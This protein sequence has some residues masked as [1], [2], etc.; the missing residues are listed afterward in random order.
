[1]EANPIITLSVAEVMDLCK[2]ALQSVHANPQAME[3]VTDALVWCELHGVA[4]HGLNMLPTYLERAKSGGIDPQ[5]KPAISHQRG[6][7]MSLDGCGTFGQ[8]IAHTAVEQAIILARE[9]GAGI[10]SVFNGNHAGALGRFTQLLAEAGLIGFMAHNVNPAVAPFGGRKAAI[11][12]NPLSFAFPGNE[13]P[14]LVDLATSATAKGKL[15]DL[16]RTGDGIPAGLALN[17]NGEPTTSLTEALKGILLPL[18]GPKGYSLAVAVEMLTGVL[19]G[20]LLGPDVPSF[21]KVPDRPQ[22]VSMLLISMDVTGF[23]PLDEYKRRADQLGQKLA[24]TPPADGFKKVQIPGEREAK[25]AKK[26][27]MDGIAVKRSTYDEILK[28]LET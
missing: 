20:G 28:H 23:L 11:G 21:H 1:M 22:G 9:H 24:S 4:S 12:T 26:L 10:V 6:A 18:G 2:Q 5:A 3:A 14:V 27:L 17:A 16:A 19:S 7:L 13:F 15:Y 8:Y 25:L